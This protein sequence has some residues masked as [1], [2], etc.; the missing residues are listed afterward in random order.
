MSVEEKYN[1]NTK[2]KEIS[3]GQT[4]QSIDENKTKLKTIDNKLFQFS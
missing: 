4:L 3:N 1:N 2:I